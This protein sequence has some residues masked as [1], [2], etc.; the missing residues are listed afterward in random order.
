MKIQD[1]P[2]PIG[3]PHR[4]PTWDLVIAD[5]E[6]MA[7]EIS[8]DEASTTLEREAFGVH[9]RIV[10][11]LTLLD[12]RE[13]DRVGRA[14]YGVPLTSHN[15]RDQ[16]VDAYQ[17]ALDLAAYLRAVIEEG[18]VPSAMSIYADHL[19]TTIRIRGCIELRD[20][21]PKFSAPIVGG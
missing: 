8:P 20:N 1:Q 21:P 5:V 13:R 10:Y 14:R 19:V 6:Q 4:R 15:G 9:M 18:S 17:E 3:Q 12:M 11:A 2:P 16:L 7:S